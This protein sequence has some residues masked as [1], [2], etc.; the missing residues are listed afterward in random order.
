[1]KF[2]TW[3]IL[4]TIFFVFSCKELD[5]TLLHG[6]WQGVEL[7][8]KGKVAQDSGAAAAIFTFSKNG[9]YTY[10]LPHYKEAGN[11]RIVENK[12]YTTDTIKSRLEK[13]VRITHLT[14]DSLF[15]EMNKGGIPQLLKCYKV[16]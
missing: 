13:V 14:N 7:L 9:N 12:L 5:Q 15:L 8:E 11:Y 1:M 10:Q 4:A 6:K 3:L 2:K 16:K